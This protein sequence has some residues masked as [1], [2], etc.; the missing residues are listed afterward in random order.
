VAKVSVVSPGDPQAD[1]GKLANF[2][3]KI[4]LITQY[5]ERHGKFGVLLVLVTAETQSFCAM[6]VFFVGFLP[7]SYILLSAYLQLGIEKNEN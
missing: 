3:A 7:N 2:T 6:S 1:R 4:A 5:S